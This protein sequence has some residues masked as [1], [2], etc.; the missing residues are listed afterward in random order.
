LS[1]YNIKVK[2]RDI[3]GISFTASSIISCF[4]PIIGTPTD[5]Q[6]LSPLL[7]I[8]LLSFSF[9]S[10]RRINVN[11]YSAIVSSI[12]LIGSILCIISIPFCVNDNLRIIR[13]SITYFLGAIII[14][15]S[16]NLLNEK[17]IIKGCHLVLIITYIGFFLQKFSPSLFNLFVF[18]GIYHTGNS[19][20]LTSFFSEGGYT[21]T[22]MFAVF[23]IYYVVQ[24]RLYFVNILLPLI[25]ILITGAGQVNKTFGEFIF[26][27]I[28][29][30]LIL[31]FLKIIKSQKL[32]IFR[33]IKMYRLIFIIF[34]ATFIY[35]LIFFSSDILENIEGYL[36][37]QKFGFGT[38]YIDLFFNLLDAGTD[39]K[40][41]IAT[42]DDNL[43]FKVA[44]YILTPVI[45]SI[46]PFNLCPMKLWS[47]NYYDQ[48]NNISQAYINNQLLIF[49][50]YQFPDAPFFSIASLIIDFGLIG[51]I[52]ILLIIALI[53]RKLEKIDDLKNK[54]WEKSLI[55]GAITTIIFD[56]HGVGM[57]VNWFTLGIMFSKN[58]I[59][60]E[61][62]NQILHN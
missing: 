8:I 30:Y 58:G 14:I 62:K 9:I 61:S 52:S 43:V 60:S 11:K 27:S 16:G 34:L 2:A 29:S 4:K 47:M 21:V 32:G 44:G 19:R 25:A 12:F 10:N 41:L 59:F 18:R 39:L 7:G 22:S 56:N 17:N 38:R 49:G 57:W 54:F 37:V 36:T 50:V 53:F 42:T 3:L 55:I 26:Y 51:L 24:K 6:L 28:I 48:F 15:S 23:I 40:Y 35:T 31:N 20:G 13:H 46:A 1:K 45:I 33:Y 5:N